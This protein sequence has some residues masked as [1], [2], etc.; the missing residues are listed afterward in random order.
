MNS[1]NFNLWM[2]QFVVP[3]KEA[4]FTSVVF[5]VSLEDSFYQSISFSS[6]PVFKIAYFSD[7][8]LDFL[9]FV[10]RSSMLTCKVWGYVSSH[11]GL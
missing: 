7:T 9:D 5:H 3:L 4:V 1:F 11:S 10:M 2:Y 8:I 6:C